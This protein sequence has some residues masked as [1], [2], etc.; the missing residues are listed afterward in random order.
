MHDCLSIGPRVEK[1][2]IVLANDPALIIATRL[3]RIPLT[4]GRS[5]DCDK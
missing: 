5:H 2:A 4:H 1:L 3:E